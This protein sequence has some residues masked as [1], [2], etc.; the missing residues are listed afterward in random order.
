LAGLCLAARLA[1]WPRPALL[2][3]VLGL[4]CCWMTVFGPA[5]ETYGYALLA[6]TLAG[7]LVQSAQEKGERPFRHA[8][9]LASWLLF[10]GAAMALWFPFGK[11]FHRL[12]PHAF[13]GLIL[14]GVL[15]HDAWRDLVLIPRLIIASAI[16]RAFCS[17]RRR[18][19]QRRGSKGTA[20]ARIHTTARPRD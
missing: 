20:R 18:P 11:A 12:G 19:K 3:L 4:T 5:V 6:P 2:N 14:F 9:L 10:T 17:D 13:A 16:R 15:L 7:A 8:M 1:A